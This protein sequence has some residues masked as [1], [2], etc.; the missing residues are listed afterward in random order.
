M[1]TGYGKMK[2]AQIWADAYTR[3]YLNLLSYL[4]AHGYDYGQEFL[5]P[6][7][8]LIE[9]KAYC[10]REAGDYAEMVRD[11]C[12]NKHPMEFQ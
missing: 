6:D 5:S 7:G 12:V 3:Y 1:Q 10:Q 2:P 11:L 9:V 4:R 8:S